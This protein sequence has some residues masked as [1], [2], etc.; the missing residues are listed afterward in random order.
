MSVVWR[1]LDEVLARDVAVNVLLASLAD[2]PA[3]PRRLLTEARAI[4]ALSHSHIASVHDTVSTAPP[5]GIAQPI[6]PYSVSYTTS[7]RTTASLMRC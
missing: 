3:F 5:M 2:D 1:A 4:A 6:V 7:P